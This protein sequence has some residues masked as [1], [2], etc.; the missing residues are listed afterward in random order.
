[1]DSLKFVAFA[2]LLFSLGASAWFDPQGSVWGPSCSSDAACGDYASA[3]GIVCTSSTSTLGSAAQCGISSGKLCGTACQSYSGTPTF[4]RCVC[5]YDTNPS[6]GYCTSPS[7]TASS[8]RRSTG[9]SCGSNGAVWTGRCSNCG[10]WLSWCVESVAQPTVSAPEQGQEEESSS[11]WSSGWFSGWFYA[12]SCSLS[13]YPAYIYA[14]SSSEITVSYY[15]LYYA[16]WN[17]FVDCGNGRSA[18]SFGCYGSTGQCYASCEYPQPGVFYVNALAGGTFCNPTVVHAVGVQ[19]PPSPSST[20]QASTPPVQPAQ[21]AVSTNPSQIY[22]PASSTITVSYANLASR[23]FTASVICGNGAAVTA[24]CSGTASQGSCIGACS[25]NPQSYPTTY[26]VDAIIGGLQCSDAVVSAVQSSTP[27]P[28]PEPVECDPIVFVY[29]A[30]TDAPIESAA[31]LFD[32]ESIES[33]DENGEAFFYDYSEGDYPVRASRIG[34]QSTTVTAELCSEEYIEVGLQP[35]GDGECALSVAPSTVRAGASAVATVSFE[36]FDPEPDSVIVNC[37]NG[38][39]AVASC[40]GAS[41]SGSCIASCAYGTEQDYPVYYT[42]SASLEG[43]QCST[44]VAKVVAPLEGDGTI[45][46]SVTDCDSGNALQGARINAYTTAP[47]APLEPPVYYTNAY[48]QATIGNLAPASYTL[49]VSDEGYAPEQVS[50]FV[51]AGE[52]TTVPVCLNPSECDFTV[53]V[54]KSPTCPYSTSPQP[55]QLEITSNLDEAQTIYLTYSSDNLQGPATVYLAGGASTIVNLYSYIEPDFAGGNFVIVSLSNGNSECTAN[56]QLPACQSGGLEI[57]ALESA[58]NAYP[59]QE[60]CYAL[61]VRNRGLAKASVVMSASPS[62]FSGDLDYSFSLPDFVITPQEIRD[63]EFCVEAPSA[64]SYSFLLTADSP[65]NDA[66]TTVSLS[67]PSTGDW[68]TDWSGCNTVDSS[69]SVALESLTINNNALSGDYRTHIGDNDLSLSTQEN[70]YN[71]EEG[72]ARTIWFRLN[73][74]NLEA[75]DYHVDFE[76]LASD[77]TVAYQRDLC[78]R[79]DGEYLVYSQ[80]SPVSITVTRGNGASSFLTVKNIGRLSGTFDVGVSGSTP[81]QSITISPSTLALESGEEASVEIHAAPGY[82]MQNGAYPVTIAVWAHGTHSS[83]GSSSYTRDVEFDCDN[84]EELERTCYGS[85]GYCTVTCEYDDAG[86]YE[87]TASI[88]GYSCDSWASRVQVR[89]DWS[90]DSCVVEVIDN[91]LESGDSSSVRVRYYGNGITS[92]DVEINCGNGDSEDCTGSGQDSSCTATCDYDDEGDY[93]VGASLEDDD[94]DNV[95]CTSARVVAWDDSERGCALATAPNTVLEGDSITFSIAYYDLPSSGYYSGGSGNMLDSNNLLINVVSTGGSQSYEA[96]VSSAL[97]IIIQSPIEAPVT[98]TV[99]VPFVVKNN[100]YYSLSS[101]VVS[102]AGLPSGVFIT[103][104]EAFSLAPN[105]ERTLQLYIQSNAAVPGTYQLSLRADSPSMVSPTK[106][107]DFIVKSPSAD[108]LNFAVQQSPV[109]STTFE[110][111]PALQ[112]SFMVSS[113]EAALTGALASI[114]ALHDGWNYALEPQS[115]ALA[116]GENAE[117][118]V[119]ILTGPDFDPAADYSA[120]FVLRS[121]DGRQKTVPVQLKPEAGLLG[122]GFFTLSLSNELAFAAIAALAIGGAYL[123]YSARKKLAENEE[124]GK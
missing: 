106:A 32:G 114:E 121:N 45:I 77:G 38:A 4:Q 92:P 117:I 120:S 87:P 51:N 105:Q 6:N 31:V 81:F 21:C 40:E 99:A 48:G 3:N 112:F 111:V 53:E 73:A 30:V 5:A 124:S 20:P 60:T 56:V 61:L 116:P 95:A 25:Y 79:V 89:D 104:I 76:L 19:Q 108:G 55:Y 10:N 52:T 47:W 122:L 86:Y 91:N 49:D 75:G 66:S 119:T 7:D 64:G 46:A 123:L 35:L 29:D 59:G 13:A 84:G 16:P 22:S 8:T 67:V 44:A 42:L 103:P 101:V 100:N 85:D 65:I 118:K 36:G 2:F 37:G 18:Y 14:G 33:T 23:P 63:L 83:G 24:M 94:G 57:E 68:E 28:T 96:P 78:F 50:A 98:G 72:E 82:T 58:K 97:Q 26:N 34:Y 11:G 88:A 90:E 71:F 17:V 12:P 62:S 107:V 70:L 41:G 113:N 69:S 27:T 39:T 80:L 115:L 1:M 74:F 9:V 15:N 109:V 102:I 110:G 43:E 93:T 54:I